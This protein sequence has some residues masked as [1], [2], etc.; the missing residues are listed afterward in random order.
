MKPHPLTKSIPSFKCSESLHASPPKQTHH[1]KQIK[2]N[3]PH[4]QSESERKRN[5]YSTTLSIKSKKCIQTTPPQQ[6]N[7]IFQMFRIPPR[8]NHNPILLNTNPSTNPPPLL[9]LRDLLR[10][11]ISLPRITWAVARCFYL[12]SFF[13]L[14]YFNAL[15]M[16]P[17]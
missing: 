2:Q 16:I 12:V 9:P 8:H 3:P 6:I 10:S 7:P 5:H 11:K 14:W 4:S 13:F 1:I 17:P 15:S